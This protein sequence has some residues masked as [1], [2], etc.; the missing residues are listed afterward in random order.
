MSVSTRKVSIYWKFFTRNPTLLT[1]KTSN[2]MCNICNTIISLGGIGK[3]ANTTNLKYHLKKCHSEKLCELEQ[4]CQGEKENVNVDKALPSTSGSSCSSKQITIAAAINQT[5]KWD[6]NSAKAKEFNYL[7]GEMIA[8]D[9]QPF[10]IVNNIGFK[11]LLRKCLPLYD[12]PSDKFFREKIVPDFYKRC[13][14]QVQTEISFV[15]STSHFP[16]S[17]TGEAI[18]E[19]CTQLFSDWQI[20]K[21]QIHL[22]LADNASNMKK[23]LIS[24]CNLPYQPCFIHTLQLIVQDGIK[25]QRAIADVIAKSKRIVTHFNHSQV[26]CEKL[27]I[28]QEKLGLPKKKLIQDV[29]TRWNSTYYLLER[30]VEQKQAINL[31][32]IDHPDLTDLTF[33]QWELANNILSLLKP[34]EE[35]TKIVSHRDSCISECI[36]FVFTLRRFLTVENKAFSGVGTIKDELLKNLNERFKD[37]FTNENLTIATFLDPRFKEKFFESDDITASVI[38]KLKENVINSH[39]DTESKIN[40]DLKEPDNVF[41]SDCEEK[42]SLETPAKK[43]KITGHT[44]FWENFNQILQDKTSEPKS[45]DESDI[46]KKVM[47][48]IS[49]YQDLPN[50]ER[51]ATRKIAEANAKAHLAWLEPAYMASKSNSKPQTCDIH[52]AAKKSSQPDQVDQANADVAGGN[53]CVGEEGGRRTF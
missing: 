13:K 45:N 37:M 25:S 2:A 39:Q 27:Q 4:N 7:I 23:G 32:I 9:N 48:E 11:R 14:E 34:F 38:L 40:K 41:H 44:L 53:D 42:D 49:R 31:N 28:I 51:D 22:I 50:I 21:D 8:L 12:I 16:G 20:K 30:L 33:N 36:P 3:S 10:N 29:E 1:D 15:L 52:T 17:H 6:K 24:L 35:I 46:K 43:L 18:A 19:K 47:E 26:A 5:K